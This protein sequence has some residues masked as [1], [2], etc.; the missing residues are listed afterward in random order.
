MNRNQDRLIEELFEVP[1]LADFR[2]L[3]EQNAVLAALHHGG[4]MQMMP[5]TLTIQ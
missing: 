3:W 1:L 4:M 5:Y 2:N